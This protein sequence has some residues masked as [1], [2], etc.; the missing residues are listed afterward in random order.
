[1]AHKGEKEN[2]SHY[3]SGGATKNIYSKKKRTS[4]VNDNSW[5][6]KLSEGF[7]NIKRGGSYSPQ[8]M[9]RRMEFREGL[10]KNKEDKTRPFRGPGLLSRVEIG[11]KAWAKE[12]QT[13]TGNAMEDP[14][15]ARLKKSDNASGY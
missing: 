11:E 13:F 14:W 3:S 12:R 1:M 15:N 9:V 8:K 2:G 10:S 7:K 5:W 4:F 6:A